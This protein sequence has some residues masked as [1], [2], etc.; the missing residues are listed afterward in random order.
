MPN[1]NNVYADLFASV[2]AFNVTEIRTHL[3]TMDRHGLNKMKVSIF[4]LGP[5]FDKAL[6]WY[7]SAEGQAEMDESGAH[8]N[9]VE[10]FCVS[11][12]GKG[13]G[14]VYKCRK[15]FLFCEINEDALDHFLS[16]LKR[17]KEEGFAS[18]TSLSVEMFNKWTANDCPPVFVPTA[19]AEP[20]AS[21]SGAGETEESE[22]EDGAN[23]SEDDTK[24]SFSSKNTGDGGACIRL[25][26]EG[27]VLAEDGEVFEITIV[28]ANYLKSKGFSV[29]QN[30]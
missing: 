6:T 28:M 17:N 14:W 26:V 29:V 30:D 9:D 27:N 25:D 4:K 12:A 24:Y 22:S 23:E 16:Y 15:A 7:N 1:S 13:K 5:L 19:E 3:A 2:T 20:T 21:E 8:F 10:Q 11:F 18:E